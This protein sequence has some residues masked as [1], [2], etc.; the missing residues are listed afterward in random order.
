[1]SFW[2]NVFLGKC[3]LGKC[4]L[5][6]CLSGQMSFWANVFLGKCT[7]GQTSYGQMSLGKCLWANVSGQMSLGKC[8]MGKCHGTVLWQFNHLA[9]LNVL[10]AAAAVVP[11]SRP[12]CRDRQ[13]CAR[14]PLKSIPAVADL[15]EVAEISETPRF[16]RRH[17]LSPRICEWRILRAAVAEGT[18]AATPDR[19]VWD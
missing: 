2:A 5:G 16:G 13:V 8:R 6:K 17:N 11:G 4:C 18:V 9:F 12:R 14:C 1:M 3:L 19:D 15:G 10:T 7:S